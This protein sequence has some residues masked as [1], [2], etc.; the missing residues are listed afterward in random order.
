MDATKSTPNGSPSGPAN[1]AALTDLIRMLPDF[2]GSAHGDSGLERT[3]ER[4][5]MESA[6]AKMSISDAVDNLLRIAE[7]SQHAVP[8]TVIVSVIRGYEEELYVQAREGRSRPSPLSDHITR[9]GALH[10]INQAATASLDLDA[11]LNTVVGVVRDTMSCDSCSIFLLDEATSMLVLRASV[12]LNPDAIGH[13]YLPIGI[14]I[15]GQSALNRQILSVPDATQHPDYVDYPLMEDQRYYSQVSVPLALRSPDRLVGVL[16]ILSLNRRVFDADELAFLETAA[17]EMAIAIEN[18]RLY[19]QTD[20]ELQRRISQLS[21]LQRMS[22]MVASTLELSAVLDL[23]M[24]QIIKLSSAVGIEIYR[25]K[26][27]QNEH[28]ELLSRSPSE[29]SGPLHEADEAVRRLVQDVM[30]SGAST[31]RSIGNH[32]QDLFVHALPMLTGRRIVGAICVFHNSRPPENRESTSLLDAFCDSAAIAIENADL[33]EEARRGYTRTSILLQE[34]HHRVRNNLQTVAALLSMQA[35]H[36]KDPN[37]STPLREAVTRI[38]SIAAIHDILSAG[39]LRETTVDT[40]AKHVADDAASNLVS[41][42]KHVTFDIA[43]SSVHVNSREATVLALLINEFVMN[44][45]GHGF[46]DRSRGSITI[47]ASKENEDAVI[48]I[49]DDG[50]G[51][52]EDFTLDGSRRLGLN[53]ARTLVEADLRGSLNLQTRVEGGTLVRVVFSPAGNRTA[54]NRSD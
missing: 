53:I 21:S 9:L 31:W 17:G 20:A 41:P 47:R 6:R 36:S 43:P 52:P 49:I 34:M 32:Q 42:D 7:S 15:T 45:I 26:R 50:A 35:R 24:E 23:I 12:G 18:A 5:G 29:E 22:R 14:G 25:L 30:R 27:G 2:S 48:E 33:Y 51:L 3:A 28:L 37:T 19:V 11:M 13:V 54:H 38:Q 4:F 8:E 1:E 40:I 39:D 10:R 46:A 44:S 16:N